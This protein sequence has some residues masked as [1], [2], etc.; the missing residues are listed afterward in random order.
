MA[1]EN[2]GSFSL[3]LVAGELLWL[4]LSGGLSGVPE[5]HVV[6]QHPSEPADLCPGG[7][8]VPRAALHQLSNGALRV[9]QEFRG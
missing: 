1:R 8:Q 6:C 5:G 9:L 2:K 4:P 7:F 3:S